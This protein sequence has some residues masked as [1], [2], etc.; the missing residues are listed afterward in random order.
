MDFQFQVDVPRITL[1]IDGEGPVDTTEPPKVWDRLVLSMGWGAAAKCAP[2]L[3]QTCLAPYYIEELTY[4]ADEEHLL[5]DA[6]LHE[7]FVNTDFLDV[8]VS[9]AFRRVRMVGLEMYEVDVLLLT[10]RVALGSPGGRPLETP[11]WTSVLRGAE[12]GALLC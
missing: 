8:V 3:T 7:V 2:Y 4:M 11:R 6:G 9:K 12:P 10:L 1:Y 5:S